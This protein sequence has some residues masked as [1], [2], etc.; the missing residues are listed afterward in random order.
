MPSA[1]LSAIIMADPAG[2]SPREP[3]AIYA[4]S[5]ALAQQA[6][7]GSTLP[8][9][10]HPLA[11]RLI[12]AGGRE[13][14]AAGLRASPGAAAAGAAALQAG[15]PVLVDAQMVAAGIMRPRLPAENDVLCLLNA[16]G[17][18]GLAARRGC[19]R[20][21]AQVDFWTPWLAGAV[22]AIGNAPT[23]LF[24]LLEIMAEIPA[25]PALVLGFA[26]GFVGAAESKRALSE[27]QFGLP[28]ITLDGRDGGSAL[29]AA[30][31]NALAGGNPEIVEAAEIPQAADG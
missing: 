22:V 18:A 20:S 24:R 5:F 9:D 26:V 1:L 13:T 8:A 7:A 14:V 12:H 27:N 17:V 30:A 10:L 16:P 28:F 6:L 23:C 21:A 19:T 15:A 31:V 4:R 11:L 2:A 25:R 3:G 29:A